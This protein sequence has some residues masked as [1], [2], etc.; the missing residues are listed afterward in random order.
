MPPY[1]RVVDPSAWMKGAKILS[2]C[3]G[4]M[5]MP[6]SLTAKRKLGRAVR[7]PR[8]D[9]QHD[10][11]AVG[12]LHCVADQVSEDLAQAAGIAAQP[13]GRFGR[14]PAVHLQAFVMRLDRQQVDGL[15][16]QQGEIEVHDLEGQ[17]AGLDLGEVEDVVDDVQQAS[18]LLRTI[19]A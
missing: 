2:S 13:Q 17:L 6:V 8:L 11:A 5:P 3:S 19:S 9:R 16:Q 4:W 10:F 18:P 7:P 1:L 14:D 12:E 15:A